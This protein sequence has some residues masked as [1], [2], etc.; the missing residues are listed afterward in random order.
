MSVIVEA[1]TRCYERFKERKDYICE[2]R[3]GDG[4]KRGSQ[5]R[6]PLT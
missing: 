4:F 5:R 6:L 1:E 3:A 2:D